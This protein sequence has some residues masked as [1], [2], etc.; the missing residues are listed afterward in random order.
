MTKSENFFIMNNQT[1]LEHNLTLDE[2][3]SSGEITLSTREIYSSKKN[4]VMAFKK[5]GKAEPN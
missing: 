5:R 1:L 4:F 3:I 2:V